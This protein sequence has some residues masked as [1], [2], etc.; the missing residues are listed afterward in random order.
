MLA[1]LLVDCAKVALLLVINFC[2]VLVNSST[3]FSIL[4]KR[5]FESALVLDAN[6]ISGLEECCVCLF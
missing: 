6:G 1:E 4:S 3:K 2:T 5:L